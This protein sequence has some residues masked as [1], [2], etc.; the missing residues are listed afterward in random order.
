MKSG[1]GTSTLGKVSSVFE[2]NSN[3]IY[4]F[5][6]FDASIFDSVILNYEADTGDIGPLFSLIKGEY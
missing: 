1:L 3:Y 6:Y 4:M 2:P 5:A